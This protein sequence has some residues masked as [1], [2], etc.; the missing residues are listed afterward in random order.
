LHKLKIHPT[1]SGYY[2]AECQPQRSVCNGYDNTCDFSPLNWLRK[3][4]N[5][6]CQFRQELGSTI[7]TRVHIY[8][9]EYR[10]MYRIP[11]FLENRQEAWAGIKTLGVY[12]R[13]LFYEGDATRF[14]LCCNTISRTLVLDTV[15]FSF[16]VEEDSVEQK[17]Q[18]KDRT[19]A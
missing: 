14:E 18:Q 12:L 10:D 7:W 1:R 19:T 2:K 5:T 9:P 13:T 3:A 17:S 4:S 8:A 11:N 16:T 15:R 6:S